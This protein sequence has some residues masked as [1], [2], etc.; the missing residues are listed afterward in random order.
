MHDIRHVVRNRT[1]MLQRW[2]QTSELCS[3]IADF[4]L[5]AGNE[6]GGD[7]QS[8]NCPADAVGGALGSI[9]GLALLVS[10]AVNTVALVIIWYLKK[11]KQWVA[12]QP[13]QQKNNNENSRD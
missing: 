4:V 11:V 7:V 13:Q 5:H 12:E 3:F 2:A 1:N 6:I 9:L 8:M 10:I